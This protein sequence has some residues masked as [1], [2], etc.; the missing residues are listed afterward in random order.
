MKLNYHFVKKGE[1]APDRIGKNEFWLDVGNRV[2][3]GVIDHHHGTRKEWSA[4]ELFRN[5]HRELIISN[6]DPD[7]DINVFLHEGPD[8]DAVFCV[9]LLKAV[10]SAKIDLNNDHSIDEMIEA[11]NENDQGYSK[12][13]APKENWAVVFRLILNTLD[14]GDY[15]LKVLKGLEVIDKTYDLLSSGKSL[16]YSAEKVLSFNAKLAIEQAHRDYMED[17]Q[18]GTI[19]QIRLPKRHDWRP[20]ADYGW[21]LADGIYLKD[22]RSLLFKEFARAD[23]INSRLG[24]GFSLLV[25]SKNEGEYNGSDLTRYIISTDPYSGLHL[26][27]LG[28]TL[29]S[30]EQAYEDTN[31]LDLPEGRERVEEGK[32]RWADVNVN[33]PWYDGRGH[34]YTIIDT[35]SLSV[36]GE[37]LCASRM[38]EEI[39]LN[40]LWD[41]GDPAKFINSQYASLCLIIPVK[42]KTETKL[43]DYDVLDI[44]ALTDDLSS[45]VLHTFAKAEMRNTLK[46]VK[47]K[48]KDLNIKNFINVEDFLIHLNYE[49]AVAIIR[50]DLVK[51][52]CL[53]EIMLSLK[54]LNAI[55][56]SSLS[57]GEIE[58]NSKPDVRTF[59]TCY[60]N[61]AEITF[62]N[63]NDYT[64]SVIQRFSDGFKADFKNRP[65][66]SDL[67]NSKMNL[68][69]DNRKLFYVSKSGYSLSILEHV[70]RGINNISVRNS[71]ILSMVLL[72]KVAINRLITNFINHRSKT[73]TNREIIDDR[74]EL[75]KLEQILF[76]KIVSEDSFIQNNYEILREKMGIEKQYDDMKQKIETLAEQARDARSNF[77]Q[78][79]SALITIIIAPFALTAAFFSG[80]HMQKKFSE[81]HYALFPDSIYSGWIQ[82]A[83]VFIIAV[84]LS[85]GVYLVIQILNKRMIERNRF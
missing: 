76:F 1:V 26:E 71:I 29:E 57:N 7:K 64:K 51:E 79:V 32:G 43:K 38:P 66:I 53:R 21:S 81:I 23:K 3:V 77:F 62:E 56:Y 68:S 52:C 17:V 6:L 58:I 42:V 33:S 4:S 10:A 61:S 34:N 41:Y 83:A 20:D 72:Q 14:T 28:K 27:G 50:Y 13:I 73:P 45:E 44:S 22:P 63:I 65:V 30:L 80:T 82:F 36:N 37:L 60:L 39:V 11:V 84:L 8:L 74:W 2:D 31:I 18:R 48:S 25:V 9:W 75:M 35:P 12:T 69:Q 16:E 70:D 67:N 55:D 85:Y 47:F 49:D 46:I 15:T 24:M 78:L 59:F 40:A 54:D 19:F 5:N